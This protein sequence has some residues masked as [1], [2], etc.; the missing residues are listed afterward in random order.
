MKATFIWF[1]LIFIQVPVNA[2]DEYITVLK[3]KLDKPV[4]LYWGQGGLN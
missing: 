3:V 4:K 2:R 1:G